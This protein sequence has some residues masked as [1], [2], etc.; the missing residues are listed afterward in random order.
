MNGFDKFEYHF[1]FFLNY[2]ILFPIVANILLLNAHFIE[3][4]CVIN[5]FFFF[6]FFELHKEYFYSSRVV[7]Q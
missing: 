5:S 4:L 6:F 7:A 2:F 1:F 3:Y